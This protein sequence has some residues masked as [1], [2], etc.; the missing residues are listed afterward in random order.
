MKDLTILKHNIHENTHQIHE[1]PNS[2]LPTD[3]PEWR[4]QAYDKFNLTINNSAEDKNRV[5]RQIGKVMKRL[6]K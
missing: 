1:H 3:A 2:G 6:N 4:R 5:A